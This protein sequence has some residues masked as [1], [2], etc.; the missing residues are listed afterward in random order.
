MAF[1]G[2]RWAQVRLNVWCKGFHSRVMCVAEYFH[3]HCHLLGPQPSPQLVALS[4]SSGGDRCP[5]NSV[6]AAAEPGRL[7]GS[8]EGRSACGPAFSPPTCVR[9]ERALPLPCRRH[10]TKLR[11]VL[12]LFPA[13]PLFLCL[14]EEFGPRFHTRLFSL[15]SK[16]RFS[17]RPRAL[18][19]C[20]FCGIA[21]PLR[22][23]PHG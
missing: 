7:R 19:T 4:C 14:G 1:P 22:L 6:P 3:T 20:F 21:S 11:T 10:E 23:S 18:F 15:V 9:E 12:G 2:G 8:I 5:Q 13:A 16:Y 17:P